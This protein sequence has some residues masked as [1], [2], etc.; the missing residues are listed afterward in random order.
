MPIGALEN[1]SQSEL[2]RGCQ[3]WVGL[4]LRILSLAGK[5]VYPLA[6]LC[7]LSVHPRQTSNPT[8][9]WADGEKNRTEFVPLFFFSQKVDP[10][11]PDWASLLVFFLFKQ[12]AW[13]LRS[14]K[15]H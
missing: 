3:A 5:G 9:V 2:E 6:A 4:R 7:G 12:T 15:S 13:L 14:S 11:I 1:S 8:L 10:R